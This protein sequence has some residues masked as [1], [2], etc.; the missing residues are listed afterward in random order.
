MRPSPLSLLL[1]VTLGI[2]LA[3]TASAQV[4]SWAEPVDRPVGDNT[5]A[6]EVPDDFPYGEGGPQQVPMGG[7]L[8]LALA[9]GA[10][11]AYRLRATD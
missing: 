8:V 7:L 2:G 5:Y 11:G 10:Y 6:T 3:A 4:P 1:I 9:G